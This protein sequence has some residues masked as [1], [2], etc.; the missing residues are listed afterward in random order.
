MVIVY[1]AETPKREEMPAITPYSEPQSLFII[2]GLKNVSPRLGR[3]RI[4]FPA[5]STSSAPPKSDL[6]LSSADCQKVSDCVLSQAPTSELKGLGPG[7]TAR[8]SCAASRSS[9]GS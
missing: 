1:P 7:R 5:P 2:A 9:T 4:L 6:F 3:L 8:V